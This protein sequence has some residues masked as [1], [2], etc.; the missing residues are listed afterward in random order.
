MELEF[1][2]SLHSIGFALS[3]DK[4]APAFEAVSKELAE[5][6][7]VKKLGEQRSLIPLSTEEAPANSLSSEYGLREQPYHSDCAS[8]P[9]PPRYL[10]IFCLNAGLAPVTTDMLAIDWLRVE[11]SDC[12]ILRDE[13]FVFQAREKRGVYSTIFQ[14]L[15]DAAWRVRYDPTLMKHE[16]KTEI[17]GSILRFGTEYRSELSTGD[18]ILIDNFKAL[19]RRGEVP[20]GASGR[21]VVRQYW[22]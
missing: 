18:W 15:P 10:S 22:G 5:R 8:W 20:I 6:F 16:R 7:S 21:H 17:F 4:D 13:V 2:T 9:K 19:H 1:W 12:P 3:T 11:S 14:K